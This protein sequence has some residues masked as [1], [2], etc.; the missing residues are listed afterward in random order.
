VSKT[1]GSG[2]PLLIALQSIDPC[3]G[4]S[5]QLQ[6]Q[7]RESKKDLN[8]SCW[9]CPNCSSNAQAG[10]PLQFAKFS[11]ACSIFHPGPPHSGSIGNFG[12][13]DHGVY[14]VHNL[15]SQSPCFPKCASAG[16]EGSIGL[17]QWMLLFTQGLTGVFSRQMKPSKHT[18]PRHVDS[19]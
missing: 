6:M 7:W 3:S 18:Q 15:W 8:C 14:P 2:F 13:Y 17:K 10:H 5:L 19:Q 9:S 11:S 4:L 16:P 12:S 1:F